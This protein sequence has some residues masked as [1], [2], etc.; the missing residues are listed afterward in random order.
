MHLVYFDEVK[1]QAGVQPYEW[2]GGVCVSSEDVE[3]VEAAVTQ[4]A[5]A[6]FGDPTPEDLTEFHGSAIL[7]GKRGF[8]STPLVDRIELL[9]ALACILGDRERI[10]RILIRIDVARLFSGSDS[11]ADFAFM[12]FVEKVEE[13]MVGQRSRAMLIGDYEHERVVAK[14]VRRLA[15]FRHNRTDY[16]FG[17]PITRIIDTVHFGRSHHSRLLQLADIFT[18]FQQLAESEGSAKEPQ[19]TLLRHAHRVADMMFPDKYKFWPNE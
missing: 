19:A 8:K 4:L 10:K 12:Y 18:W 6:Y 3:Q 2:I 14:A 7:A 16:A 5:V 11:P 15:Q 9:K 1:F 17:R 13:L